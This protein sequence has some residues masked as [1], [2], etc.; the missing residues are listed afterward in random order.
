ME[1]SIV[2]R[3]GDTAGPVGP[4]LTDGRAAPDDEL[5][6]ATESTFPA[7]STA[8]TPVPVRAPGIQAA[9]F[10]SFPVVARDCYVMGDEVARGGMGRI[11]SARDR[12]TGRPVA[13]KELLARDAATRA[14]FEREARLTARLQHPAIVPLYEL[15]KWPSGE[16]FY[17]MKLVRGQPLDK[18]IADKR[19][20]SERLDLLPNVVAI[21]DAL[22]YAHSQRNIHRD[23][24]PA[25][26]LLGDFGE[27]LVID[28]GLAKD[29]GAS[30]PDA[31]RK[32]LP[33]SGSL[34]VDGDVVG[35]PAYM[36]PEQALGMPVDERADVYSLGALLYHVLAGERPYAECRTHDEVL[37]KLM[38]GPPVRGEKLYGHIIPSELMAIVT[39]AMAR[40][41][42]GRYR[43]ARELAIDLRRYIVQEGESRWLRAPSL[44]YLPG[45]LLAFAVAAAF[46]FLFQAPD[47]L[48]LGHTAQPKEA[49][50]TIFDLYL[51]PVVF[52]VIGV[53]WMHRWLR[54][55]SPRLRDSLGYVR[56]GILPTILGLAWGLAFLAVAALGFGA[57]KRTDGRFLGIGVF[58]V[59]LQIVIP[60]MIMFRN[61]RGGIGWLRSYHRDRR[62][63]RRPGSS[64]P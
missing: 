37:R 1:H 15:G 18:M 17:S 31:G 56:R 41:P 58:V 35:T 46:T 48:Q 32:V 5:A 12:R 23:L 53:V 4:T 24:K 19:G 39:K 30:E 26:V 13:I 16:P 22:A 59:G 34:T 36:A 6:R 42:D 9:D 62:R 49:L 50:R 40:S 7:G 10:A 43:T 20:L 27:T 25:N 54:Q 3:N 11:T 2:T 44:G 64:S 55:H 63:G 21:V 38:K 61:L 29:L 28:W 51:I 33:T 45:S 14:R 8:A 47:W 57:L 60:A 52:S